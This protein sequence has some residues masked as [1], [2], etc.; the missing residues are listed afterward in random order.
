[1]AIYSRN[2]GRRI[3]N[4][5]SFLGIQKVQGQETLS[6]MK[7]GREESK[8]GA[9]KEGGGGKEEGRQAVLICCGGKPIITLSE[10]RGRRATASSR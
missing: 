6:K 10:A 7:G 2:G 3:G 8:E 9:E 5:S 4:S 1:M